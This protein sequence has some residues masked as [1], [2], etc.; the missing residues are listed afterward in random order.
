[1]TK[2][3]LYAARK[4]PRM[5]HPDA[6]VAISNICKSR[7]HEDRPRSI[8]NSGER[9]EDIVRRKEAERVKGHGQFWWGIGNSLGQA[10]RDAAR[11][12]GGRLPVLFSKMLGKPKAADSAPEMIWRWTAW[13]DEDGGIHD[14]PPHAKVISRGTEVK[15]RHYA[16]V[17]DSNT[18]LALARNGERFE[19]TQ[20]RTLSGKAPGA[21]QVTA[22]LRGEPHTH[23]I[24]P[25]EI[26]FRAVLVEPWAV[27]LVRPHPE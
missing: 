8:L 10:V 27:K 23:A 17:C 12:Q 19:P 26:C 3:N 24:G 6:A 2:R 20:C 7:S 13:E 25:Y 1:M 15:E 11:A 21:S 4:R 14:I 18:P 9:L 5:V 22:L 16:L